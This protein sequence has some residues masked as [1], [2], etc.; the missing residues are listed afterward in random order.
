MII[1]DLLLLNNI[2]LSTKTQWQK[3]WFTNGCFDIIHPGHIHTFKE[4]KKHC[5]VLIVAINGDTSPYRKT[6]PWRP[7]HNQQHRAIILDSIKYVDYVIFFDE[8]TPLIPISM[9]LP[10]VL[11]KW[12]D[13]NAKGVVG[14]KEVTENWWNVLIIPTVQ[15]YS[16]T[17]SVNKILDVK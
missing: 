17:N 15:W 16:T 4:A 9:L 10:N 13:Y 14:Y 2:C 6:K 12:W 1:H 5:D 7:I 3:I 11:V 8:E